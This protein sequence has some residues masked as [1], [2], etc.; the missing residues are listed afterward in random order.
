[1]TNIWSSRVNYNPFKFHLIVVFWVTVKSQLFE[2]FHL[3]F[4]VLKWFD[5][6]NSQI[7]SKLKSL[8]GV[9]LKV[10]LVREIQ[11]RM[12]FG[13]H[14]NIII[15]DNSLQVNKEEVGDHIQDISFGCIWTSITTLA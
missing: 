14:E 2:F 8:F 13:V 9:R 12:Y 15:E 10:E 6:F 1:M 5:V 4:I 3:F 11:S 7:L